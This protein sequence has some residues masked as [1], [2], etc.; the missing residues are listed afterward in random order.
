MDT[1]TNTS[2]IDLGSIAFA[3]PF[4]SQPLS[5]EVDDYLTFSYTATGATSATTTTVSNW[6]Q[7]T[8]APTSGSPLAPLVGPVTSPLINGVSLLNNQTASLPA[9]I[10]WSAPTIG[11]PTYYD[12]CG[13]PLLNQGGATA[14]GTFGFC[15]LTGETQVVIPPGALQTGTDYA[16]FIST[17]LSP[18]SSLDNGEFPLTSEQC[19]R[20][21]RF[22]TDHNCGLQQLGGKRGSLITPDTPAGGSFRIAQAAPVAAAGCHFGIT[23][24]KRST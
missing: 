7:T 1:S 13:Y 3:N 15:I 9:T 21:L 20:L 2:D 24:R 19:R 22:G 14:W 18:G 23:G 11:T 12:V 5:Y 17:Y 10:A 6:V 16:F 4:S 8:T